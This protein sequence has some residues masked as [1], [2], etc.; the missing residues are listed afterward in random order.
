MYIYT[1]TYSIHIYYICVGMYTCRYV[2]RGILWHTAYVSQ[3]V[4]CCPPYS[5]YSSC[6]TFWVPNGSS[7]VSLVPR[8][9]L[10][11]QGQLV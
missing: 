2:N 7:R 8:F 3:I 4:I 1:H 11:P 9:V 6:S 5:I 10:R